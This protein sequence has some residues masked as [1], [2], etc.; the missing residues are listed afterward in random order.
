MS[1]LLDTIEKIQDTQAA[2]KRLEEAAARHPEVPSV[3]ASL[4]SLQK[5]RQ[6]LETAFSSLV[7]QQWFDV[8]SYRILPE[9]GE[10]VMLPSLTS[11]LGEFQS[12]FT[13]VY[14]T[15]KNGP[16]QRGRAS[17]EAATATTFGFGYS[18]AGSVGFVLTLPNERLLTDET[19]LDRAMST[20]FEMAK[21]DSPQQ[22]AGFAKELGA[23]PI[24][25]M[26]R[27]VTSH[28]R[29]GLNVDI[30]WRREEQVR[31][32]LFIQVPEL[33]NLQQAIGET[34]DEVEEV[35]T[36]RG[37]LVG[38][39]V[40][41]HSFHIELEDGSEIKGK[42]AEGVGSEY[43]VELP[44]RYTA[45]IRKTT[46]IRYASDEDIVSYYLLSLKE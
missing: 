24:R 25:T 40:H 45:Q 10:H 12:L 20:V 14:D 36:I 35:L 6:D 43:T 27:W 18:F 29:S 15:M 37:A 34:S 1:E 23:A 42:M 38:A 13:L 7:D 26:Y 22:I 9:R 30:G 2:I 33:E 28:V 4:R 16:K 19:D 41:S 21:A 8:C 32:S 44:R 17:V 46:Q 39:D 31:A 5:R 3:A 11:T